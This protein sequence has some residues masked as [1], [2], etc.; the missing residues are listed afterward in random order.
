M[1][2]ITD[3]I[4]L[5]KGKNKGRF[6][7]SH[8]ILITDQ[9]VVLI[10]TGCGIHILK[11]LK[12]EYELDY[13]IN[14]HTHPDHSA[15]NWVFGEKPIYVPDEGFDTSG[16]ILA[17]S[18]R[19]MSKELAPTW[20]KF[21][22]EAMNFKDCR[23]TKSFSERTTFDFGKITLKPIHTPGHTKDHYCFYE[24]RG[25]ILFTFD[26]DLTSFPWYGHRESSLQEFK[27]SVKQLEKFSPNIIVSSHRGVINKNIHAE[28]DKFYEVIHERDDAIL[29]LLEREKTIDQLV[30]CAPIYGG[31][32]YAEPLLRYW[33]SQ[34]IRKHLNLLEVEGKVERSFETHYR[35]TRDHTHK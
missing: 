25:G 27:E 5:I 16:N 34:M 31:F 12:R 15:G 19:F 6:P 14:S 3:N 33:E 35:R 30:E 4:F 9:K 10:D 11:Q 8:S 26:Y 7:Y 32:P 20:Q 28:F 18:K 2:T 23:P 22:K 24:G 1:E 17:L 21:V 13:I 29:S